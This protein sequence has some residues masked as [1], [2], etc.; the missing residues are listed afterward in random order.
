MSRETQKQKIERLDWALQHI[1]DVTAIPHEMKNNVDFLR[2]ACSLAH[3]YA[4]AGRA[5]PPNDPSE[6]L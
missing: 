2:S 3:I 5:P 6:V 1:A 4:R